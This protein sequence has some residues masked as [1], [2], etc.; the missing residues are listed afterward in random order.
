M[1]GGL[2]I[3]SR[4]I[5]RRFFCP[6]DSLWHLVSLVISKLRVSKMSS[7]WNEHLVPLVAKD[8]RFEA[9]SSPRWSCSDRIDRYVISANSP[10]WISSWTRG[11]GP[12][13]GRPP[14]SLSRRRWRAV[15]GGR[16]AGCSR[17]ASCSAVRRIGL[18][19]WWCS[20]LSRSCP[21][22]WNEKLFF[23]THSLA[24]AT[25]L[26]NRSG[27]YRTL[28]STRTFLL[29]IVTLLR[30]HYFLASHDESVHLSKLITPRPRR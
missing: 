23:Q 7:I 11:C 8:P 29:L 18:R 22:F 26:S 13:S 16:P 20:L 4:A 27:S 25:L 17:T 9:K 5:E 19:C 2:L 6:P 15:P 12:L 14:C 24:F 10:A 30:V 21:P 3:S 28:E 1:M